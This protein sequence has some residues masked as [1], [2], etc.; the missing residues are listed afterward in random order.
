MDDR[1]LTMKEWK[2]EI[3]EMRRRK[4]AVDYAAMTFAEL[5]ELWEHHRKVGQKA[6]IRL[7]IEW[8]KKKAS[9]S[10]SASSRS[11]REYHEVNILDD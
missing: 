1:K 8:A 11:G 2:E 3:A 10:G 4:K 5:D 9:T 6:P 7:Q